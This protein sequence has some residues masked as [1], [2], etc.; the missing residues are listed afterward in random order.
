MNIS[1]SNKY[2]RTNDEDTYEYLAAEGIG[3]VFGDPVKCRNISNIEDGVKLYHEFV[4]EED[5]KSLKDTYGHG[6]LGI[7]IKFIHEYK[8]YFEFL[9]E[10]WFSAIRDGLKT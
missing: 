8:R 7:G 3:A 10:P 5:I 1:K 4:N 9:N 6:F 2:P